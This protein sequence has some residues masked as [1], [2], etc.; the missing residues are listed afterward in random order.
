[1]DMTGI[2]ILNCFSPPRNFAR[3]V[4]SPIPILRFS[5]A[6]FACLCMVF[7][8]AEVWCSPPPTPGPVCDAQ[9]VFRLADAELKRQQYDQADRE[10]DRLLGCRTLRPIDT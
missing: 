5:C 8:C 7:P 10:L 6:V 3:G 2:R 1:M 9:N 4:S